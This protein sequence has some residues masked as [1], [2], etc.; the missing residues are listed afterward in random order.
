[1]DAFQNESMRATLCP[2]ERKDGYPFED[3]I[4][5]VNIIVIRILQFL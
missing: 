1:M 2:A 4:F 5:G 3:G